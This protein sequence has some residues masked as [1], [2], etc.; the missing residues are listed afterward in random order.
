MPKELKKSA[1]KPCQMPTS[2]L[3]AVLLLDERVKHST[4]FL[5]DRCTSRLRGR[6]CVS[7]WLTGSRGLVRY[8]TA[9]GALFQPF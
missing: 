1:S 8:S 5:D 4:L 6:I 2:S 9:F 7:R 3:C